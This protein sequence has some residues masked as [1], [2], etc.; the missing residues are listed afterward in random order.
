M[1]GTDLSFTCSGKLRTY[2]FSSD[3]V[4]DSIFLTT[5]PLLVAE[6][7]G[8]LNVRAVSMKPN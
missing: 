7:R 4:N 3:T 6:P 5:N 2:E 8:K 1:E